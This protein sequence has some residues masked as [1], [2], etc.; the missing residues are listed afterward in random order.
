M[1][2]NIVPHRTR[3]D[4]SNVT[5]LQEMTFVF[6][7]MDTGAA[8]RT[9][10]EHL[11]SWGIP[12]VDC[13]IG[14]HRQENSLRGN[15]R[16]TSAVP[17]RHDHVD[18]RISFTDVAADEYDMNFQTA[19]LNMLN[20]ALAVI[21]WKK[22]FGYYVDSGQ[23]LSSLYNVARGRLLNGEAAEWSSQSSGTSSWKTFL[24]RW[25]KERCTSRCDIEQRPIF[26]RAVVETRW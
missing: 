23:E 19:D 20:A 21:K 13:G 14:L 8:K 16:M 22:I 11:T 1:H 7:A 3:V 10:V 2:R 6:L 25:R 5:E 15:V 9:M 24:P 4:E 17:G 12:F 18:R 26:A